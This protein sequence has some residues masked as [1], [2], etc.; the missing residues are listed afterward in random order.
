MRNITFFF[1]LFEKFYYLCTNNLLAI[2]TNKNK[3][4]MEKENKILEILDLV[5][6]K[7]I[8]P[9]EALPQ[10]LNLFNVSNWVDINNKLPEPSENTFVLTHEIGG[11]IEIA[12]YD[13][14]NYIG[15]KTIDA[16][17][18]STQDEQPYEISPTHWME[19]PKPPCC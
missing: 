16:H 3:F 9:D 19:L 7:V 8:S 15:I 1:V 18:I 10:I 13:Y 5:K 12:N 14:R 6:E 11:H 2:I 17:F 4:S